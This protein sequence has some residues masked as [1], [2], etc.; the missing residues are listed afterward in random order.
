[1]MQ[2]NRNLGVGQRLQLNANLPALR[3]RFGE[4]G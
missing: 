4:E 3:S 2:N 1:M